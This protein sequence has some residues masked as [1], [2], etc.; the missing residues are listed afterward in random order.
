MFYVL[1]YHERKGD[2][3]REARGAMARCECR[4]AIIWVAGDRHRT[5]S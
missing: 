1:L 3:A 2:E 4:I 5:E